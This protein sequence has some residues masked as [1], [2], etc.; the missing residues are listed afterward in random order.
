MAARFH[1][2]RQ[3]ARR[4]LHERRHGR[5]KLRHAVAGHDAVERQHR[6]H[7]VHRAFSSGIEPHRLTAEECQRAHV[8]RVATT[9]AHG[10]DDGLRERAGVPRELHPVHGRAGDQPVDVLAQAEDRRPLRRRVDAD[11][12]EHRRAVVQRVGERVQMQLIVVEQLAV[13]PCGRRGAGHHGALLLGNDERPGIA[14]GAF[15]ACVVVC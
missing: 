10:V 13:E 7:D 6:D 8:A 11:T 5:A 12:F 15:V 14:A 1:R 3:R 2:R 9:R 4:R